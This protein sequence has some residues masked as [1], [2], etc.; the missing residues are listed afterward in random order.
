MKSSINFYFLII[1]LFLGIAASAQQSKELK[2]LNTAIDNLG[3]WKAAAERGLTMP[4]PQ[5]SATPATFTGSEIRAVS[6]FTDDSPDVVLIT[7][8]TSQSENSVFLNPND[9]D[10]PLNSNNSTNQPSGGITLYGADY[11]YSFDGGESWS[12]SMNGAGGTNQGDPTTAI[13]L[14][15]RYYIGF[16]NNGMGQSI[17]YSDDQGSTWTPKT[18]S[19]GGGN[20]LDKN[21]LWIDNST[22]SPYEGNLYDAWTPFGGGNDSEIE[23]S[24]SSDDGLTWSAPMKVSAGANAGYLCQGVNIQTGPNGEVYVVFCI[25]DNWPSDEDAIGMARSFDGGQTWESFRIIDNIRGIRSSGTGKDMRVN[26]FP[27]MAVDIS[28]GSNRGN[29][30]VT[31]TNSGVPGINSGND[32]DVYMIRSEDNGTTWSAPIRVN[33]DP[34]GQGKKHYF[35]W[36]TSDPAS[37][38]LSM[39]FYDDRNVSGSQVEVFCANSYDAGDTWEDFKVSDVAFSPSPIPGLASQYFGDYIGISARNGKVYPVWT[40]NRTGTALTY[41]SP[42]QTST[43]VAP[44]SLNAQVEE[45]TGAVTLTWSHIAGPTFDHYNIYRGF[46]LIGSTGF[47][48]FND[49]LP[50][51]GNYRYMVTAY[52]TIEGESAPAIAD[53]QWGHAQAQVAPDAIEVFVVPEGTTSAM[54]SLSNVGELPLEYQ[55]GFSL[56]VD[57]RDDSRDYCTG[58]GG[59]GESII[60]VEYG[61]IVNLSA[62][63]GYEDFSDLTY[64]VTKGESLDIK[65]YNSTNI[66]PEDVCGIWIDWN[67]NS[68]L[69]D[70]APVNVSGSPGIGPYT[71]T[72]TVPDEAKNGDIRVRIRIKRGGTLSPCGSASNG[73]VEDY[74]LNVLG[75]V[76]ANPTEG[77]IPAGSFQDITFNFNS[78]GLDIGTYATNY[79]IVSNDPDNAEL[80][81]PV[82]MH[83]AIA[84]VNVTA[85]KDS[86]CYGGSTTLHAT[87]TGGSGTF[88]YSWTSNP[89]G[90]TSGEANPVVSP[91]VTTAYFVEV[92]DGN[93]ILQDE[94]TITV[95][96]LPEV[97]L[98]EDL[99]VCEGEQ[100]VIDAGA[101]FASYFWNTGESSQSIIVT[102]PGNYWVDV[103]NEFGCSDRDTVVFS[104]NPLPVVNLGADQT[105]C[106]G[107]SVAIIAGSGFTSYLWNTGETTSSINTGQPGEYWVE[108]TDM[109][110]CS[111]RDTI[112]LVMNPKPVVNLGADQTFCEGA[113]V[114]IIAGSGFTS[115][116]WN[117]GETTSSIITGQPG[118]YWVEVTDVN[119]CSNR[120]TIVLVMNPKPLV[121]LG[122][123]QSFCEGASVTI[124][125]G[126]GFISYLWNTG[127]TTPSINTADQGEYWVEVTDVNTC[128]NR[129]TIMLTMN[130][131]PVVNLGSDQTFCE[132]SS[133]MLTAGNDF[134]TYLWSTG[135]TGSSINAEEPGEYRVEVTDANGCSNSD[136]I[137]VT[138]V[139][140][141]LVDLGPDKTFCEGTSETLSAGNSFV[142]YLWNTGATGSSENVSLPGEY[143]VEV[144]DANGCSNR[145]TIIVSM[146]PRPLL[147][148]ITSGPPSVDNFLNPVSDFTS[149]VSTYAISYEWLLEPAEAGSISGSGVS[150][151]VSWS[152]GFAGT[153]QVSVKGINDCGTSNYSQSH[154]VM[155]YSSQE[156]SEKNAITGIKLFPNP[157]DGIF[158]VQ[159]NSAAEQEIKLQITTSGGNLILDSRESVPVGFYQKNFNLSTLPG[160]TYYLVISDSQGRMLS[161]K[162]VVVQ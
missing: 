114:A 28:T 106:E 136:T 157:N 147:P 139:P 107:A 34:S 22:T 138:R 43:M 30:Y 65:V 46:A 123:D 116:L 92:S 49:V 146:D 24:R 40:D 84:A 27:V 112:V 13:G 120:D 5:R 130:P 134:V 42:Y 58:L 11:L 41:T 72:I 154:A 15:G 156:I 44:T 115:Y 105:F 52:Y 133:I 110:T 161:R 32:V 25:Y 17:S 20:T 78:A 142:T 129:D 88:T 108:V 26:A 68:N 76:T 99:S 95:I 132:G 131:K 14:N 29:I 93:I 36:I 19:A 126:S 9:D 100:A 97:D 124:Y 145:D 71:A 35:G 150:A 117:T 4:N 54:M 109:N 83:V 56:P 102:E 6:V 94:I 160:G 10:N 45:E 21:H 104:I 141:P 155:V 149:S 89:P 61:D 143:W 31:W 39:I 3:Y 8:S 62:C 73:E 60:R 74:S 59:C 96:N 67:Q 82:T 158:I 38:T 48:I 69:Q 101:G 7:G 53:V 33:Q 113:S 81:V 47:P 57:A 152:S 87:V 23:L 125:A 151:Q 80:I 91:L 90:F 127:E 148:E 64:L 144:T 85:D 162:Q 137:I 70:D 86:L 122:A 77:T 63:N 159:F 16:I 103:A 66:Y 98:G 55:C 128:S 51:Y 135:E 153:A 12:G 1:S 118:E 75:W 140:K 79:T 37:G 2:V 50:T 18:V 111:N 121:N 119:T